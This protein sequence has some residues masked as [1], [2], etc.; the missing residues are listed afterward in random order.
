MLKCA[1]NGSDF[2]ELLGVAAF[3]V[4]TFPSPFPKTLCRCGS[5]RKNSQAARTKSAAPFR[6]SSLLSQCD[7]AEGA[8]GVQ[9]PDEIVVG[10]DAKLEVR[11]LLL[12]A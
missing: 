3:G 6:P 2:V 12:G 9:V 10:I 7:G 11:R 8:E 1:F 4:F 5:S